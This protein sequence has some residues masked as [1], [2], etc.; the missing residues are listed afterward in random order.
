MYRIVLAVI[1]ALLLTGC[2]TER[3]C[4]RK[5][6]PQ[7]KDSVRIEVVERVRDTTI[8][9]QI[10]ADTVYRVDTVVVRNG[11]PESQPS[12]LSTDYATSFA[13]VRA[14]R[15]LHELKQKDSVIE[16]VIDDAVKESSRVEYRDRVV[17]VEINRL[18]GWQWFQIWLGR[19]LTILL[20]IGICIKLAF[21]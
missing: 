8:Y 2:V 14:G 18:T 9:I 7:V 21:K 19:S 6:P 1:V 13:Q 17:T 3:A 12:Y 16:R 5:F 11:L 20:I 4:Q 15:L 10:P